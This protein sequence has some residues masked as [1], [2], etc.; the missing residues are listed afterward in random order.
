MNYVSVMPSYYPNQTIVYPQ[1]SF[2]QQNTIPNVNLL[3]LLSSALKTS[4]ISYEAN[5]IQS[6]KN[7]T[8]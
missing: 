1:Q 4:L 8:Q 7:M 6:T 2:I 3:F 5:L